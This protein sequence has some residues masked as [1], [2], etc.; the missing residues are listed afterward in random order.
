[1]RA[2]A[3]R[4]RCEKNLLSFLSNGGLIVSFFFFL[5]CIYPQLPHDRVPS[6]KAAASRPPIR[7]RSTS[8]PIGTVEA[9]N[10]CRRDR[11]HIQPPTISSTT[12]GPPEEMVGALAAMAPPERR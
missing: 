3:I 2:K 7:H 5:L 9:T 12:F 10:S 6:G 1:M 4:A 8:P 11:V